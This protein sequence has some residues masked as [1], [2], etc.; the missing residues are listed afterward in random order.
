MINDL[1]VFRDTLLKMF[2]E[3]LEAELEVIDAEKDDGLCLDKPCP[4]SYFYDINNQ[5]INSDVF[6]HYGFSNIESD[7]RGGCISYTPTMF[8]SYYFCDG[9][10][11]SNADVAYNKIFRYT[12]AMAKV[13]AD[14]ATSLG[15]V[16]NLKVVPLPPAQVVFADLDGSE[17]KAGS[18]EITGS[19]TI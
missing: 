17:W 10:N 5:A 9:N 15:W 8:F 4:D 12:R 1:E 7:I 13:I 19:F 18:I 6:I 3:N 11:N 2:Q 16:S 14:R